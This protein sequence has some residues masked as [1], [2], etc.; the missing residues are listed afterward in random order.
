MH[1]ENERE[2]FS[3]YAE[4]FLVTSIFAAHPLKI[5]FHRVSGP[6]SITAHM[7]LLHSRPHVQSLLDGW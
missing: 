6:Y 2:K 4:N 3:G 5:L 1:V 7:D